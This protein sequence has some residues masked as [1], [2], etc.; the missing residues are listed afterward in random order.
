MKTNY[1]YDTSPYDNYST[2]ITRKKFVARI[3]WNINSK[4]KLNM[5]YSQ[6]EGGEPT[7]PSTSTSGTGNSFA[8]GAGRTDVN[9]LWFSNSQYLQGANFYSF[10]AELNSKFGKL[11]NTLRPL[12]VSK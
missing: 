10:S 5:R 6:V 9:A 8:T 3:D 12:N 1:D 11:S 4:H 2:E 7:A